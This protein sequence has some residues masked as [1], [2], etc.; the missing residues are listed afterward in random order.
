MSFGLGLVLPI[1]MAASTA[2][3]G[4]IQDSE[5]ESNSPHSLLW[6]A[7][8]AIEHNWSHNILVMQ[9]E[10]QLVE[11]LPPE[12]QSSLPSIEQTERE[13]AGDPSESS[14]KST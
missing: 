1:L 2:G 7:A 5:V 10:S 9:I 3:F 6:Y 4:L 8:K 13:L 12:L 11:S 14:E